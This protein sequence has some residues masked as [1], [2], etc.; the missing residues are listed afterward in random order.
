MSGGSSTIVYFSAIYPDGTLSEW[1]TT[2]PLPVKLH[3]FATI[4]WNGNIYLFGGPN[5]TYITRILQDFSLDLWEKAVGVPDVRQ[6]LR[7]G[8][9]N[10]YIYVIGGRAYNRAFDNVHYGWIGTK[11]D[12]QPQSIQ[13]PDCTSGWS[14]ISAGGQAQNHFLTPLYPT[15]FERS[16]IRLSNKLPFSTQVQLSMCLKVRSVQTILFFGRSKVTLFPL[17]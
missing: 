16:R 9:N 5:N 2:T 4:E 3:G 10:G 14:R 11:S 17:E 15:G 8:V 13:H 1:N 12:T 6:G 7:V